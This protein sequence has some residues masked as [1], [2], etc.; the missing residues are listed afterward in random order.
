MENNIIVKF[1]IYK[2]FSNF[3]TFPLKNLISV[4]ISTFIASGLTHLLSTYSS[5]FPLVILDYQQ[6]I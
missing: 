4:D 3:S 2:S 1:S 6:Y 5:I